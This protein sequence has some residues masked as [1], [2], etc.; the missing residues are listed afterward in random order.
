MM[1]VA[2]GGNHLFGTAVGAEKNGLPK[3]NTEAIKEVA[4]V[5]KADLLSG[6]YIGLMQG[7][8]DEQR[9]ALQNVLDD[10]AKQD[11][12]RR[13]TLAHPVEAVRAVIEDLDKNTETW[14]A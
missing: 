10:L 2:K 4:R 7:Y 14:L 12:G 1:G 3:I 11:S 13:F 5:Y 8:L 6:F 9:T